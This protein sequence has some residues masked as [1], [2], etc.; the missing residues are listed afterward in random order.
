MP[1]VP[2]NPKAQDV[3]HVNPVQFITRFNS[4]GLVEYQ[5]SES[6]YVARLK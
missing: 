3:G 4:S 1:V 6:Q 2:P 5:T